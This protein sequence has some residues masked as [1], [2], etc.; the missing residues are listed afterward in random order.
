MFA[1]KYNPRQ[2]KYMEFAIECVS[3]LSK[4]LVKSDTEGVT[5]EDQLRFVNVYLS[6][7]NKK[8]T[9]YKASCKK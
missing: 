2:I 4:V 8:V 6:D 3:G 1:T 9:E 7:F 5:A